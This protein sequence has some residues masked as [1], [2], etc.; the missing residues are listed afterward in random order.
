MF[1]KNDSSGFIGTSLF[2][3]DGFDEDTHHYSHFGILLSF[4]I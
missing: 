2:A 1:G 3:A 4:T